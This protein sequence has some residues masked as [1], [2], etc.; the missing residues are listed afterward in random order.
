MN[1]NTN[2]IAFV[3]SLDAPEMGKVNEPVSISVSFFMKNT[4]G[5]FESFRE[6][7]GEEGLIV[8]VYAS[9]TGCVCGQAITE[10]TRIYE[11]IPTTPGQV[12]LNF[13]SGPAEFKS[14]S[15]EITE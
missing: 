6:S 14:I 8:E 4:C 2:E 13:R 15:I 7:E 9:Y 3:D 11:F 12:R 1:C 10:D 5:R